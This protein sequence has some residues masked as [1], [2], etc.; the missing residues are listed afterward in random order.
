MGYIINPLLVVEEGDK[1]KIVY[2]NNRYLSGIELG[3]EEFPIQVLKDNKVD[4]IM[5]AAK[6]YKEVNLDEI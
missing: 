6:D 2:G 1:Y 3:F 5:K 4:T